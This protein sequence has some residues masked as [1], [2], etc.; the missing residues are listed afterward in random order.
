MYGVESR[1]KTR[2]NW[3]YH[4]TQSNVT[5]RNRG[6]SLQ[7]DFESFRAEGV[8]WRTSEG[9]QPAGNPVCCYYYYYY[10]AVFTFELISCK[11]KELFDNDVLM[12][13]SI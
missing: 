3:V 8:I 11:F 7:W 13:K 6:F 2:I 1:F 9:K 5:P 10:K 4:C 12:V